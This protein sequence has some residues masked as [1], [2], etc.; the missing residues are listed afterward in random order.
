VGNQ[1]L[2]INELPSATYDV[3]TLEEL[4]NSVFN[5]SLSGIPLQINSAALGT[6]TSYE[7]ID[8]TTFQQYTNTYLIVNDGIDGFNAE[9]DLIIN[10]ART[11]GRVLIAD[12]FF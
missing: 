10:T 12:Y 2:S 6:Y 7:S 8:F 3:G 11:E 1:L 9:T 4:V 5:G